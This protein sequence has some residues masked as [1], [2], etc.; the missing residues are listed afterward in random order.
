MEEQSS[1][2]SYNAAF[3]FRLVKEVLTTDSSI[4]DVC[5][6]YGIN[7]N[8]YYRWQEQ[9][10]ESALAGL[11]GKGGSGKL[12]KGEIRRITELEAQNQR[13]K[14]VVAELTA[15]NIDFKKKNWV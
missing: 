14:D 3:K 2:K 8:L 1:R 15:E 9:F 13:L 11:E 4:T 12:G 10:F 5:K 6:K 7:S